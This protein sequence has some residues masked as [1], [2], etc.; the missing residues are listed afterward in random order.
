MSKEA[1]RLALEALQNELSIDWTNNEEFNASAE[2]M[3]TAIAAIKEALAQTQELKNKTTDPF[4]SARVGDYNR[5]WNDCL[6]ASGIVKQPEQ[7]PRNVRERWNV[8]LDGNDLLVCF[9][10]HE[11]GDKCQYERY[12]PQRTWVGLT[13]DEMHE[14]AGEFPWTPTGLKCC[15]AI[16]AKLKQKNM[17]NT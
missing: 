17:E 4:E 13:D 6:F 15:R 14:C 2:Q 16:E 9:N 12:S 8:E 3:Y 10:D 1:L 11:K 5:G 7:E